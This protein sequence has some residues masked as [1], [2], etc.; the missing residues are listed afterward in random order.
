MIRIPSIHFTFEL[1]RAGSLTELGIPTRE[2]FILD[3]KAKI[4]KMAVG[5]IKAHK[6]QVRPKMN[7]MAVMF[8]IN[9]GHFWTHLRNKE[10][11]LCF[12]EVIYCRVANCNRLKKNFKCFKRL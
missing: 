3:N 4:R 5:Y 9:G 12:P 10:F 2:W 11:K 6:L 8:Y 7:C 1:W